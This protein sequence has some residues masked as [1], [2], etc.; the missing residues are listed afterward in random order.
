MIRLVAVILFYDGMLFAL[1]SCVKIFNMIRWVIVIEPI[2]FVAVSQTMLEA[3]AR[4]AAELG[5]ELP[6]V[7]SKMSDVP[8]LIY[9]YPNIDVFISRGG[10]AEALN[11]LSG[12]SVVEITS[13]ISDFLEP[14][15]RICAAG[16]TKI[17]VVAHAGLI[18]E[19][20][21]R[22]LDAEIFLC[23][24]HEETETE[25][26]IKQLADSGVSGIVGGRS[27]TEIARRYGMLSEFLDSGQVSIKRA[28]NEAVKIARAQESERR[29]T[30]LKTHQTQQHV[31]EIYSDIEQAVAAVEELTASSEE[32]A[33]ISQE[34]AGI[35]KTASMDINSTAEIM[36]IIKRIAQQTNLLGLNAAIEAAR[37][38]EYGR[39]FSIVAGEVRKL[40]NESNNS[41]RKVNEMLNSF[42]DSVGCVLKN[43]EQSDMI[44]QEQAKA[45]Q[46]IARM[47][48]AL[49]TVDRKLL[50]EEAKSV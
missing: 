37:A 21:F 40:A 20:K 16:A 1:Y 6:I 18:D 26:I 29:R 42:H 45:I 31:A 22:I 32:L 5:V 35:A 2:L 19:Q 14:I 25:K 28:I 39:G 41:A 30:A 47:L 17:G 12:K 33:A 46:E 3:A 7:V 15:Q 44:T 50:E 4:S 9:N 43:V 10:T 24:W 36:E 11:R 27:T 48:E 8:N 34:A 23:P 13:T 38:G 49:Q